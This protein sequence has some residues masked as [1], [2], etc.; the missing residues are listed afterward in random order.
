MGLARPASATTS[1]KARC[2]ARW[3][4]RLIHHS[5]GECPSPP[6]PPRPM[7]T[8]GTPSAIGTFESVDD[9]AS[10]PDTPKTAVVA[11]ARGKVE[12]MTLESQKACLQPLCS[13]VS[14]EGHC[15]AGGSL[16]LIHGSSRPRRPARYGLD[17]QDFLS[18]YR[19]PSMFLQESSSLKSPPRFGLRY[20]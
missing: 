2:I 5:P 14:E 3:P 10:S 16:R 17:F 18:A 9:R 1:N 7:V 4:S 19:P 12:V 13:Q 11:N 6:T 15:D 8:A 20:S